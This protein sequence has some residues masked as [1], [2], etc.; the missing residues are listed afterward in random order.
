MNITVDTNFLIS[1]TQWG[2]SVSHKLLIKLIENDINIYTTN[3]ILQEFSNVLERDF[4][5]N[6]EEIANILKI[7]LS[8]IYIIEPKEKLY[9]IKDD[10]DDNKIV[11]CALSSYSEYILT[12]DKHLLNL[13]KFRG[14]KIINPEKALK[15][16]F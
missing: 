2:Y 16:I 5:Y 13:K 10:Q 9:I 14:I 11:E 7:L 6:S 12:Y 4:N 15:I 1:A 3:D 8:F